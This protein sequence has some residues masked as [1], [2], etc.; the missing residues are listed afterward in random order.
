MNRK[1]E[2]NAFKK[3]A[4]A[5]NKKLMEL[6]DVELTRVSGGRYYPH[7]DD[8]GYDPDYQPE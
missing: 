2:R 1:E 5:L 4:A 8:P 7:K 3:E 6:T